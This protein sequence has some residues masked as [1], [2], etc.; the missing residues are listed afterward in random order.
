MP[1][2]RAHTHSTK[3]QNCLVPAEGPKEERVGNALDNDHL[4]FPSPTP[5]KGYPLP[6]LQ[7]RQSYA[8]TRSYRNF[9]GSAGHPTHPGDEDD[10]WSLFPVIVES[11]YR[12]KTHNRND[13]LDTTKPVV[14]L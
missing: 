2:P 7:N 11:N 10:K 4:S 8:Y 14:R 12:V 9:S 13:N 5:K 1:R 3:L 6:R